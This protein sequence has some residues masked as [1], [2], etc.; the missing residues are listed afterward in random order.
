MLNTENPKLIKIDNAC[1]FRNVKIDPGDTLKLCV[2]HNSN[3]F[4]DKYVA[5]VATNGIVI[6]QLMSLM[7]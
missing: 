1:A 7:R 3:Y 2:W 5:F 6:F 4:I